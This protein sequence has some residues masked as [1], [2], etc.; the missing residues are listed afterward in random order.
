MDQRQP[1]SILK[2]SLKGEVLV[3]EPMARHTTYRI[4]GPADLFVEPD[5]IEDLKVL[6]RFLQEHEI[7]GLILGRGSNLLVS[8]EGIRGVVVRLNR[9]CNEIR[10]EGKSVRAGASVSMEKLLDRTE[11][12]NLGGIEFLTGIPGTLGGAIKMNAGAWGG[13]L[14]DR[15]EE[16]E[17]LDP[18]GK[19]KRLGREDVS[20]VYRG[21]KGLE[22]C[23]ILGA[24]LHLDNVDSRSIASERKRLQALRREK[25]PLNLP[26]CGSVFKRYTGAAPP[27][28]LIEKAG[29]KGLRKGRAEVS[30]K[31]ANFIVNL[32]GAT[33]ENVRHLILEVRKRVLHRFGLK[34]ALEVEM[35]GVFND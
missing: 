13:E 14:G 3:D 23:V 28:E 15:V 5:G 12:E 4:G 29:C 11:S 22:G 9:C 25:Q 33:A 16:I 24:C 21:V 2:R 27:G 35:V 30:Q 6:L 32:G 18:E 19:M 31:H 26:S 7:F 20:F 10:S 1:Y 17:A 34:L 8:D